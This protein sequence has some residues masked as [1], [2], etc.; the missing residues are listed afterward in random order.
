MSR[1]VILTFGC[2]L[3]AAV[4]AVVAQ[5]DDPVPWTAYFAVAVLVV[6]TAL[7]AIA[8]LRALGGSDSEDETEDGADLD[9]DPEG[10][11]GR[12]GPHGSASSSA[13]R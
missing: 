8:T 7:V 2:C 9:G 10:R 6:T 5:A 3:C 12:D 4:L 13:P 1:S 11:R